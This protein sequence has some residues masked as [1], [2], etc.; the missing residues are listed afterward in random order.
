MGYNQLLRKSTI[1][2]WAAARGRLSLDPGDELMQDILFISYVL[3][4]QTPVSYDALNSVEKETADR[5]LRMGVITEKLDGGRRIE[6]A[7]AWRKALE[8][9][10]KRPS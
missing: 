2:E 9:R 10:L 8:G 6:L 4:S 3:A 1:P 5:L 7:R